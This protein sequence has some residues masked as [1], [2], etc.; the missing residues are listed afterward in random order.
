M[1]KFY[2]KTAR[3]F[4]DDEIH[5]EAMPPDVV[6]VSDEQYAALFEAQARGQA[7]VPNAKGNPVAVDPQVLLTPEQ[8][9]ARLSYAVTAHVDGTAR[10]LGYDSI[11]DAIT[12]ADEPAVPKYQAE[13]RALRAWRSLVWQAA[14]PVLD[15]VKSGTAQAPVAADLIATLPAFEAPAA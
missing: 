10:T 5:E 8:L 12:Y 3:G 9:A 4:F 2:S 15:A 6:E 13:G 14:V 7:I 1:P 11:A